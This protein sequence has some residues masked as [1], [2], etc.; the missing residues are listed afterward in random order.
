MLTKFR[1][2]QQENLSRKVNLFVRYKYRYTAYDH[3]RWC[4]HELRSSFNPEYLN[5]ICLHWRWTQDI[6]HV[7]NYTRRLHTKNISHLVLSL[8]TN[9]QQVVF[10]RLV[11]RYHI[12][13]ETT[14]WQLVTSLAGISDL[15]QVSLEPT[16]RL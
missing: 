9:R 12:K 2:K 6:G 8:S 11:S 15:L 13:F 7:A 16:R 10:A 1:A 4:L 5:L 14:C 3:F